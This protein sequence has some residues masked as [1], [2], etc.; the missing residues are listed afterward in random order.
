MS[1]AVVRERTTLG[2]SSR[3]AVLALQSEHGVRQNKTKRLLE[4]SDEEKAEKIRNLVF[5]NFLIRSSPFSRSRAFFPLKLRTECQNETKKQYTFLGLE[6]TRKVCYIC[7]KRFLKKYVI[8]YPAK[9][10]M[11]FAVVHENKL[12]S[13]IESF[14]FHFS[15]FLSICLPVYKT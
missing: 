15:F 13:R 4:F 6:K 5:I 12:I 2:N 1:Q 9:F 7:T 11:Y 14:C 10:P 3:Q 8:L